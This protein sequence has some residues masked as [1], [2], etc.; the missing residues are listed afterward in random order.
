MKPYMSV[1]H[2]AFDF[3]AGSQSCYRVYNDAIY[4]TASNQSFYDF[5]RLLS[6]VRLG[7]EQVFNVNAEIAGIHRVQSVLSINKCGNSPGLLRFCDNMQGYRRL[8]RTFRT[9]DL[10]DPPPG[11]APYS[12][13]NIQRQ[14]T[15]WYDVHRHLLRSISISHY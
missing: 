7:N 12:K 3:S 13:G 15:G 5:K 14:G 6:G 8:A 1:A 11:Y 2:F 9:V 4:S 10:H